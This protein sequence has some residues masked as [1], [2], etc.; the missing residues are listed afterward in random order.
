MGVK[1]RRGGKHP[2]V[3]SDTVGYFGRNTAGTDREALPNTA[4]QSKT[5]GTGS[6]RFTFYNETHGTLTIWAE[7]FVEAL[8]QAKI[9]GYSRKNYMR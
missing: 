1:R 8:R 5:I 9:R 2:R 3:V 4:G 7:S 6:K